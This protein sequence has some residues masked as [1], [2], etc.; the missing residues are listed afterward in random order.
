MEK[1]LFNLRS[2]FRY[3]NKYFF[4]K[5]MALLEFYKS[6]NDDIFFEENR[7]GTGYLKLI[8]RN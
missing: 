7:N 3:Q 2:P 5:T 6:E 4:E 1:F 8:K